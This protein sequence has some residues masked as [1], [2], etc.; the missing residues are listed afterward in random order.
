MNWKK[1]PPHLEKKEFCI[2][3]ILK[4]KNQEKQNLADILIF[5]IL[6]K[7]LTSHDTRITLT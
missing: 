7:N 1:Q 6:P 5:T 2:Y 4:Y 3:S